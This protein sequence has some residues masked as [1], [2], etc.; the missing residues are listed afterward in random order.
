MKTFFVTLLLLIGLV[1]VGLF[2][3]KTFVMQED[4]DE[5]RDLHLF[6][7]LKILEDEP[8][9]TM[10]LKD[11]GTYHIG[12]W[13][14]PFQDLN[15]SHELTQEKLAKFEVEEENFSTLFKQIQNFMRLKRWHY[16]SVVDDKFFLAFALAQ[17]NYIADIFVYVVKLEHPQIKYEY[18]DRKPLGINLDFAPNSAR[19][20]GFYSPSLFHPEEKAISVCFDEK[21]HLYKVEISVPVTATKSNGVT[22]QKDFYATLAIE[23]QE[24]LVLSFPLKGHATRPAYVHKS[25]GMDTNGIIKFGKE[26]HYVNGLASLDWTKSMAL[27]ETTWNWVSVSGDTTVYIHTRDADGKMHRESAHVHFGINLS[28][29][30]YDLPG[31]HSCENAVWINHTVYPLS[32]VSFNIPK[33]PLS[34]E[35]KINS[36]LPS[37]NERVDLTFTPKGSREDHTNLFVVVSEFVQPFGFF[38]GTVRI[39]VNSNMALELVL[40]DNFGVVEDH[41]AVW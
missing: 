11:D 26:E 18:H 12:R 30:V 36:I 20:C 38:T 27:H 2:S 8:P 7:S 37:E 5:G 1:G 17:F 6:P 32:G 13:K 41:R 16:M 39:D 28:S 10:L 4:D 21:D 22:E 19:G 9:S 40:N 24:S 34:R 15:F 31:G 29:K 14:R 23:E 25:A 33:E 35:W 3:L